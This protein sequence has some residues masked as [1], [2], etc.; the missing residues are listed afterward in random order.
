MGTVGGRLPML[1]NWR[2]GRTG[3]MN[4]E[5]TRSGRNDE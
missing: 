1:N 4:G 3:G 2:R 5:K